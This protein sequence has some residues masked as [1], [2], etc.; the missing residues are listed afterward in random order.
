MTIAHSFLRGGV[1][2]LPHPLP[3]PARGGDKPYPTPYP[4]PQG[5]GIN[6]TPPNLPRWEGMQKEIKILRNV[7]IYYIFFL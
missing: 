7:N 5:A 6:P 3:P 2:T 4:L 1:M